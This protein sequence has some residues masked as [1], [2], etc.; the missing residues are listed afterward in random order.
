MAMAY[1]K[2]TNLEWPLLI[3]QE[4][5]LYRAYG[6]ERGRWWDIYNPASILKYLRLILT[7]QTPGKPGRDWRQLGG[8]V[9]IDPAGFV[10]M[11][12]I[13]QNPHDRPEVGAM[14]AV[15]DGA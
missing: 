15:V 1:V 4:R 10:R 13:S 5:K 2:N 8:N 3:D 7:G 12:H 14:L 6:F 11:I 9:L